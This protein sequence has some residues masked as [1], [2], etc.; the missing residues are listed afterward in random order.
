MF[1]KPANRFY[2]LV[3]DHDIDRDG[4]AWCLLFEFL[5]VVRTDIFLVLLQERLQEYLQRTKA[6]IE[7]DLRENKARVTFSDAVYLKKAL[8]KNG[9]DIGKK[10]N[11][12][13]ATGNLVTHSGLDLQQTSGFTIVAERLNY[14]RYVS[15][16]RSVHRG[17]YFAQL[18][19]TTVRKL[20]PE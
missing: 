2:C 15:H 5:L 8:D 3:T 17:A 16:F 11:Y 12:F 10:L 6:V 1:R 19:T 18:R 4:C 14:L 7:K 20:L 13:L 9:V